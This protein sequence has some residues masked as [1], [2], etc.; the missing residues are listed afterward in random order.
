MAHVHLLLWPL[1][2]D[3][4]VVL[5]L[6]SVGASIGPGSRRWRWRWQLTST[7]MRRALHSLS[8][9]GMRYC[10][11]FHPLS[12]VGM[13][14]CGVFHSLGLRGVRAVLPRHVPHAIRDL[15]LLPAFPIP[16]LVGIAV[17]AASGTAAAAAAAAA[18]VVGAVLG[19]LPR[20]LVLA[21]RRV[22]GRAR[23]PVPHRSAGQARRSSAAYKPT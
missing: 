19:V 5:G 1:A 17:G 21:A 16:E 11:M 6:R 13:R 23:A 18:A 8:L 7:R 10:C 4:E 9:L 3:F 20:R 15:R 22:M 14:T 12:F 2:T